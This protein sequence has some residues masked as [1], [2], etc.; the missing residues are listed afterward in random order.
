MHKKSFHNIYIKQIKHT[1]VHITTPDV[2]KY[3]AG[4]QI[5]E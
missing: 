3:S 5:N 2:N 1:D 4:Q